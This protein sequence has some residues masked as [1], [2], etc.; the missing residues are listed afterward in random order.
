MADLEAPVTEMSSF[1]V[2][3]PLARTRT[4]SSVRRTRPEASIV[5]LAA[6]QLWAW[7]PWRIG[8][9]RYCTD[10]VMCLF[11]FEPDWFE[12]RGVEA[13]FVGHPLFESLDAPT[14]PADDG[15]IKL[16][17][18][19]GSRSREIEKNWPT[20]RAV[21][22]ALKQ[23]Y[24]AL[25]ARIAAHDDRMAQLVRDA[26]GGAL[27]E[28][29]SLLIG[30]TREALDWSDVVLAKSGTV[31]LEVASRRRPMVVMYNVSWLGYQLVRWLLTTTTLCLPNLISEWQSGVRAVPE[32]MPHFGAAEPVVEAL[33]PL[34]ADAS[35]RRRQCEA[36][37]RVVSAFSGRDFSVVAAE[38][39]LGRTA[40]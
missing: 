8:K 31:T 6:P 24:P 15:R 40:G 7:A 14:E 37:D 23:R 13:S 33:E 39:L 17:L 35:S 1:A 9:L 36:L 32:L 4:P 25:D 28:G 3:S 10:H 26:S 11:P 5:H 16:A 30:R 38:R 20:M 12:H 18:L 21:F 29:M 34:L 19:P 27:P 22:D 2:T